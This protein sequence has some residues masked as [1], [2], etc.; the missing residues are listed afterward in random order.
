MR[1]WTDG[2]MAISF[3]QLKLTPAFAEL[4]TR[5]ELL[6]RLAALPG[7]TIRVDAI[8]KQTTIRLAALK[9]DAGASFLA[10][11]DGVVAKLRGASAG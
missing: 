9:A 2:G 5:Q 8:E 11:M 10:I 6:D 3:A 1:L 4:A 7:Q